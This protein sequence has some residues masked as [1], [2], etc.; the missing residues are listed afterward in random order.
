[1][2]FMRIAPLAGLCVFWAAGVFGQPVM[3]TNEPQSQTVAL[4]ESVTFTVGA[5]GLGPLVYEWQFNGTNLMPTGGIITTVAGGGAGGD[6]VPATN[7]ALLSPRG[8]AVDAAGNVFIA[9]Q[10][11]N[12][13]RR[14]SV[15]GFIATVAGNESGNFGGDGGPATTA[16][17]QFPFG[18][19]VDATGNLFIADFYDQRIRKVDTNGIITT[20]AGSGPTGPNAGAYF[21]DGGA[22][23]NARL[24][25]PT[26][27]A[28]DA[29]DNLFIADYGNNRIRKVDTN[30]IITTVAGN[31]TAVFSGDGGAATNAGFAGLNGVG[32]DTVGNIYIGDTSG[33]RV[34]KV[35]LAGIITTIAGGE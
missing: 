1:M 2:K 27:V 25:L 17:L 28:V 24:N 35:N 18:V 16:G 15:D 8:V 7:A 23:T 13:I 9:D 26:A 30:G 12:T 3:I 11:H 22:A 21:G 33:F 32:V 20:V 34:R 14:V 10:Q 6:G 29:S 19:V 5:A 31:G 4:G